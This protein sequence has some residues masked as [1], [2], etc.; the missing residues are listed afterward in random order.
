MRQNVD[1][2]EL[3]MSHSLSLLDFQ[4]LLGQPKT[5]IGPIGMI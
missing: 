1:A 2:F 4:M 3:R 5:F